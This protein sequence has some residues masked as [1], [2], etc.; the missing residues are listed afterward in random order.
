MRIIIC[1]DEKEIC[2]SLKK[3][4]RNINENAEIISFNNSFLLYEYLDKNYHDVDVIFMDIEFS[5]DKLNGM[6]YAQEVMKIYPEIRIIFVSGYTDK[7]VEEIFL[8]NPKVNVLGV[9]KK[10]VDNRKLK[11]YIDELGKINQQ[12][13][14]VRS[15]K[16]KTLNNG[17]VYIK[18]EDIIYVESNKRHVTVY[19]ETSEYEGFYK[20]EE[21]MNQLR[22]N[23]NRFYWCNKRNIVNI[24]KITNISNEENSVKLINEKSI[25]LSYYNGTTI[26]RKKRELTLII[27]SMRGM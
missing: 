12:N 6:N 16:F 5:N 2:N 25:P 7:Y 15:L 18:F 23:T 26:S 22:E 8:S 3:K 24:S 9:L 11:I 10:P 4:I 14:I 17:I 19:T 21:I 27:A 13:R 20:I 1:D